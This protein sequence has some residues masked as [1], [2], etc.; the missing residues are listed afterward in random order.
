MLRIWC[1]RHQPGSVEIVGQAVIL[2][3][4]QPHRAVE[5]FR[6]VRDADPDARGLCVLDRDDAPAP[7]PASDEPGLELFTW[8]R[9]HLESYLL[10]AAALRRA[11]RDQKERFRLERFAR[12]SLPPASDEPA[13]RRL[14]A[15]RLLERDGPL[16]RIL[17]RP[18]PTGTIARSLRGD[19]LHGDVLS[20]LGRLISAIRG[21]G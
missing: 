15:K 20:L 4:R 16:H 5:H 1:E 13:W 8:G 17:G 12:D 18:L 11:G 3:G 6:V 14:D 9:R 2:G 7:E 10:V 19:E 21:A